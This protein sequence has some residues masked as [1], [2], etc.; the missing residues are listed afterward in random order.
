MENRAWTW[1]AVAEQGCGPAVRPVPRSFVYFSGTSGVMV[2][3]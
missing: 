1:E 3:W 2:R